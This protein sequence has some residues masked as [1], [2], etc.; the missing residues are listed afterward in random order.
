MKKLGII[1]ISLLSSILIF[2]FSSVSAA[3]S[4]SVRSIQYELFFELDF[5]PGHIPAQSVLDYI[6]KYYFDQGI[7]LFF[8]LDE[9]SF[10]ELATIDL[11]SQDYAD[12]ISE[13]EFWKINA[14]FNDHD[15]GYYSSCKWIL[16]GN[17]VE[18]DDDTLGLTYGTRIIGRVMSGNYIFIADEVCDEYA[19]DTWT[20]EDFEVEAV[21][22][23]HEIGHS[24]GIFMEDEN[25]NELYDEDAT[26]VM[27]RPN[28]QCFN[29]YKDGKPNWHYSDEYWSLRVLR[30]YRIKLPHLPLRV[31]GPPFLSIKKRMEG[32]F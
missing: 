3:T 7:R 5:L 15:G 20:V 13:Q 11:S 18:G 4:L 21:V 12:G 32:D 28:P 17:R 6:E 29:A 2:P 24:I 1:L 23:M 9:I 16:F 10:G 19:N 26:S 31:K 25:G 22:L 8:V 14:K 27:S 30:Y